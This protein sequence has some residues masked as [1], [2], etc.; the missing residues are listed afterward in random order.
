L[1]VPRYRPEEHSEERNNFLDFFP[2]DAISEF[3]FLSGYPW[4]RSAGSHA[5]PFL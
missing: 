1:V 4:V 5:N 3:G 2:R